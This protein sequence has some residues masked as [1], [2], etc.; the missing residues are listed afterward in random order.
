MA[1]AGLLVCSAVSP[2]QGL[3]NVAANSALRDRMLGLVSYSWPIVP[4]IVLGTASGA[5]LGWLHD[6][7][8]KP[9]GPAN[10]PR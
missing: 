8:T 2:L 4:I 9:L 3:I 1:L 6:R 10:D 7:K 5:V